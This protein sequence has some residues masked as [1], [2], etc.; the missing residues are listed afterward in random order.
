MRSLLVIILL[1]P[2][3]SWALFSKS[4]DCKA[5]YVLNEDN[6]KNFNVIGSV[7]LEIKTLGTK[8]L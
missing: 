2:S 8:K 3:I 6:T 4:Y 7:V 1:F 5:D